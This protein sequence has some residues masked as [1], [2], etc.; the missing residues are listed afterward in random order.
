MQAPDCLELCAR[1][2]FN[3]EKQTGLTVRLYCGNEEIV[4]I[5][6][7][8]FEKVYFTLKRDQYYTVEI[9]K[10]GYLTR[11][12]G[13]S[14]AIPKSVP[15]KPIFR[16]EFDVEMMKEIKAQDDFY[17]DFPVALVSFNTHD[18]CFE[19]S[20]KYTTKIKREISRI[21]PAAPIAI[22]E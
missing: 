8:E 6:S 17:L 1:A 12:I 18:E 13:I 22:S 15:L 21:K 11:R 14:T 9:S 3:D 2:V 5:D 19:H 16:F 10:P 7:T 20:K 4:K